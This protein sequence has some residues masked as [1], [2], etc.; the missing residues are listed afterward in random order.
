MANYFNDKI[1]KP[2]KDGNELE[3]RMVKD[4][5]ELDE[6]FKQNN[7]TIVIKRHYEEVWDKDGIS[8]KP[9]PLFALPTEIPV[10]LDEM[11]AVSVRYSEFS[12]VRQG[13]TITYPTTRLFMDKVMYITD[14]EKDK[15]W[16][17]LKATNFVRNDNNP[18][19]FMWVDDPQRAMAKQ[20][21]DVKRIAKVDALLMNEESK[22]YNKKAMQFI[23]DTFGIEIGQLD[24]ESSAYTIRE[25]IL[26]GDKTN[27][28]EMNI[29][30]FMEV[31]GRL[32]NRAKTYTKEELEILAKDNPKELNAISR[33]LGTPYVPKCTR[34]QQIEYILNP[35]LVE[36]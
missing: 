30:K 18:K 3:R 27:N 22:L 9:T 16:F 14:K 32:I 33:D 19:A 29:D 4:Y 24:V 12:P 20:A 34:E 17:L 1:L 21:G 28:P 35:N 2:D 10:Y 8:T 36:A 31:A 26:S 23:A 15:A 13:K 11:G 7:G 5:A 6:L 25:K